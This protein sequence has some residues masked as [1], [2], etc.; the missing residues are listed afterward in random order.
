MIHILVD[1]YGCSTERIDNLMDVYEVINKVINTMGVNA[2]MPPQLIP[3]YYCEVPEDVGI[4]AFVLLKGGHFT[5]HTFPQYGC[6]FADLLYDG[7]ISANTLEALLKREFPCD[8]FF[9]KRVDRDEFDKNDMGMY[10]SADFGP[11]YMVKAKVETA[12]TL[13]DY[14]DILDSLPAK[15]GMHP[16]TR[17]CVLKDNINHPTYLSGIAV[18]AESHIAM[19]YNMQSKEVLMDIFSCKTVDEDKYLEVMS[20]MFGEY[21]DVLILRGR[22]NEQRKDS[23][24]N[25]HEN[26]KHWQDVIV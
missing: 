7:F 16:I 17:P 22:K 2:I 11:H 19:H 24:L 5:I 1:S 6:Y 26:H 23:Q 20:K 14:M 12:P 25:K 15:I 4:S 10:Q 21:K 3:Y 18:I 13:G 9:M 8:S